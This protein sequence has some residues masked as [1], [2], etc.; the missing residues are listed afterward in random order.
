MSGDGMIF[1]LIKKIRD[2]RREQLRKEYFSKYCDLQD[3]SIYQ[4]GFNIDVRK[5]VE[6]KKYVKV[7]HK[8]VLAGNYIFE[9][10]EGCV[11]IGDRVHIGG[12]TFISR[13]S[14][15]IGNDVTIA[16]GCVFYDHNSHSSVWEERKNDTMQE[17]VDYNECG[18]FIRNKDW[19]VV[20]SAPIK[21]CEKAW[22]GMNCIILKGVTIGEGAIVAAGSVV[23]KDV[24][25]WTIVGGNPAVKIGEAREK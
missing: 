4:A 23:T 6:G 24:E 14:I 22:I 15:S 7:G 18:D 25:P 11:S 3:D 10:D 9:T 13:E 20:K 5:P 8:C 12:S 19:S 17:Y 2:R 21:I 16:W 1:S